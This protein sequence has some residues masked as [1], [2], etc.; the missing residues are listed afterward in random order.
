MYEKHKSELKADVDKESE[1]Q[2]TASN[3]N[4][5]A[6]ASATCTSD[7]DDQHPDDISDVNTCTLADSSSPV[8][9]SD[10]IAS[11]SKIHIK[12]A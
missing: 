7:T 12:N 5:L 4:N 9:S 2:A 6:G 11:P 3:N 10:P 8:N 1:S